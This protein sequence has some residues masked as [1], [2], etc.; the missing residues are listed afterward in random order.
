MDFVSTL[1]L[2]LFVFFFAMGAVT[3]LRRWRQ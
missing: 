2:Y 3:L 1:A